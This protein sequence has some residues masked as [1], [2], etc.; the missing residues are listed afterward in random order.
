MNVVA[1]EDDDLLFLSPD[2]LREIQ[3]GQCVRTVYL[4]A[5]DSGYGKFYWLNRQLGAEA[6]YAHMLGLKKVIWDQ[7]TVSLAPGKYVTVAV[8]RGNSKVSLVF[9]NLPDGD[10]QGQ[11]FT[12]SGDQSLAKLQSGEL[13]KIK[14][15][16]G[17][18]SYTS[19]QLTDALTVLM[20][21][22]Q[23]AAVHTQADV[24]SDSYPDHSDHIAAGKYA[25]AAAAAYD[26]QLFGDTFA[27]PVVRYI[28]YPIHGY[29]ANVTGADLEQKEATFLIYAKYD[30]GVCQSLAECVETPTYGAYIARQY[31]ADSAP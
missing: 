25:T 12:S 1:H 16:D 3:S 26:Q 6:A 2:L 30:G 19:R 4:T 13:Q 15:V 7:Q 21:S 5:G 29:D 22:Y 28:G 9:F 11:G 18:S 20:N 8:P 31:T 10:L 23:P 27:V 17:Q 24:A 14:T